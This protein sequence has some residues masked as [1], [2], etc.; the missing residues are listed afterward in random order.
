MNTDFIHVDIDKYVGERHAYISSFW[1][2]IVT[3]KLRKI[4]HEVSLPECMGK[5]VCFVNTLCA[6]W[7][8]NCV[9]LLIPAHSSVDAKKPKN[10]PDANL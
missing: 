3:E 9:R 6:Y 5:M 8:H 1:I 10:F 7:V 4:S 2:N